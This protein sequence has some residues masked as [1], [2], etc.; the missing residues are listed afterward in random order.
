MRVVSISN[1]IYVF[2]AFTEYFCN[3]QIIYD[4]KKI[5]KRSIFRIQIGTQKWK[6]L[7]RNDFTLFV[8]V[9][10]FD[11]VCTYLWYAPRLRRIFFYGKWEIC[12]G[13]Y[14]LFRQKKSLHECDTTNISMQYVPILQYRGF[15]VS[16]CLPTYLQNKKK[17]KTQVCKLFRTGVFLGFMKNS[18]D[19]ENFMSR[20]KWKHFE[21]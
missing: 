21:F 4:R 15:F 14:L 13:P 6:C 3:Y 16:S 2:C 8:V 9:L 7:F 17:R 20:W 10:N 19:F 12:Q 11:R 18:P 5:L 1:C